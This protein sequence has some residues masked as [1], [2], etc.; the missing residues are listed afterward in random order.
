MIIEPQRVPER[1]KKK[2]TKLHS[3]EDTTILEANL[4]NQLF[5]NVA[6]ESPIKLSGTINGKSATILIDSGSSGN[7]VSKQFVSKHKLES[8]RLD[9]SSQH[10]VRLAN[11][12][13][14][15]TNQCI[16]GQLM[17]DDHHEQV[18]LTVITLK[19]YDIVLGMPWLK[20]HNPEVNWSTGTIRVNDKHTCNAINNDHSLTKS[21]WNVDGRKSA[22]LM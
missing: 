21:S 4:L 3:I 22:Q 14:E 13:V 7:F 18:E 9:A 5:V 16:I 17:I 15:T 8:R 12:I 10:N 6:N 19:G 11:G 2:M 20:I 1:V